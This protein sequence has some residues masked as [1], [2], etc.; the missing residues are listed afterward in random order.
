MRIFL[1]ANV[2][3]AAAQSPTGRSALLISFAK[4]GQCT[5]M[6][7]PHAITEAQRNLE[8]RYPQAMERFHEVRTIVHTVPE[9]TRN[10]IQWALQ[11]GLPDNDAPILAAAVQAKADVLVTGDKTHFGHL[12]G[13]TKQSVQILSLKETLELFL[14]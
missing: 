13:K 4:E 6:T 7:S 9:A 5:C 11:Q 8:A 3:F 2:L 1:D 14:H 12:F 10:S